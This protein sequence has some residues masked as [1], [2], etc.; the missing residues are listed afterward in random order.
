MTTKENE[1]MIVE[2]PTEDRIKLSE[3]DMRVGINMEMEAKAAQARLQAMFDA[4]QMYRA[5]MF[6]KYGLDENV[7]ELGDWVTGFTPIQRG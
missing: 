3:E 7:Y 1:S 4:A 6:A 5:Q 2:Q